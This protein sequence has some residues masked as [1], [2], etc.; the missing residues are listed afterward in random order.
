MTTAISAVR[1][2]CFAILSAVE[3]DLRDIVGLPALASGDLDILPGDVR[4]VALQR[5]FFDNQERPGAVPE[6]D[7][8]LLPYTD[9]ADIAKIIH[10]KSTSLREEYGVDL[11]K[12]ADLINPLTP[13][14]NRVCH[15]RPLQ[16]E[17]LPNFLDLAKLLLSDFRKL[18]WLHVA[19]LQQQLADDPSY[20]L[21]LQI[22]EFWQAGAHGIPN[23]LPPPDFDE[24]SFLGRTTERR[25][26]RKHIL[27]AHPVVTI[28]G[29]GGV[30]KT[31]LALQCVYE[32]VDVPEPRPFDAIVWVSLKTKVLSAAGIADIR[33]SVT[34]TMG[35]IQTAASAVG[36]PT[37]VEGDLEKTTAE[38]LDY[39]EQFRILLVIDNFETISLSSLRNLLSSVPRGSKVL[40]TSRIGLGE[41][42]I[43][44]K[45][46][47]L[48]EKTAVSLARRYSRCLNA[49]LLVTAPDARL[50]KYTKAL[51]R[52]PLLIKWFVQSVAAGADPD[53]LAAGRG[54]AFEAAIRF[55]FENLFSLL[56]P[57]E[58]QILVFLSA[59]RRAL[60]LTELTFLLRE[61]YRFDQA[62]LEA[63]LATLHSSSMLKRTPYDPRRP[64]A[65]T[66][67]VLTDVASEYIS[68]FAPPD[69]KT[70][71]GTQA[72]LKKLRELV[73]RAA[74][75]EAIYK[76]D[77]FNILANTR[78]EKICAAYLHAA[79][80]SVREHDWEK[81]R[82]K[83]KEAK[84]LLPAFSEAYRIGSLV[85]SRA[86]NL[87]RAEEEIK[88]AI[89]HNP[90][91]VLARYQYTLFLLDT[92]DD[93]SQALVE[94][95]A[96]IKLD[97]KDET[98]QSVRALILTRLG[99]CREAIEIYRHVLEN[100]SLRPKKW[101]V[102]TKDQAAEAFRRLSE[103]DQAMKD[104]EAARRHL[105]QAYD[106]L[107][108]ALATGDYD[109]RTATLYASV[110][111]E[112]MHFACQQKDEAFAV[113]QV[114]RLSS[115]LYIL[116]RVTLRR[117]S[118]EY[119]TRAFGNTS[120]VVSSLGQVRGT[121]S[122]AASRED[123][124]RVSSAAP[125]EQTLLN[126]RIKYVPEGMPYGFIKDSEGKD[127]FV[128]KARLKNPSDWSQF[129]VGREVTFVEGTD[130]QGRRL[131][132][133]VALA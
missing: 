24:T 12:V 97:P 93:S 61:L 15:S 82:A 131:A 21:R 86:G 57:E 26:V 107:D 115:A 5:F 78:D 81:A 34:T 45:L 108:E 103:Q 133:Q 102:A 73:E 119:V 91:S 74:V 50:D 72:A 7:L 99:R 113:A 116:R 130:S 59:A 49:S 128:H 20:V 31:A 92:M 2:T 84:D 123:S 98:L 121:I 25:E 40:I 19:K 77:V 109:P 54:G 28:V 87:Y 48:D 16:E 83:V 65:P 114:E 89:Q 44:Y 127:W 36:I 68:R 27:G 124:T 11:T 4:A 96:A 105:S 132:S 112:G 38:L 122:W 6:N 95:D 53:K 33:D 66:Q 14:R 58:K 55:C 63:A 30:G 35:V 46:D 117:L 111:E 56:S 126:G 41:L 76:L 60:T 120:E 32:I 64:S 18:P 75:H 43:R 1:N 13:A 3:E 37:A 100:I 23:N 106:I 85:E 22:P 62:K 9:F 80:K 118:L 42:E 39:L 47:P 52:N 67:I 70:L 104:D 94:L 90:L 29:E 8:E 129:S 88:S 51:F 69:E 125:P 79:L 101:R 17:D 71:A 10:T 110:F